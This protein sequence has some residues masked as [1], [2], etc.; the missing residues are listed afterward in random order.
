MLAEKSPLVGAHPLHCLKPELP[1]WKNKHEPIYAQIRAAKWTA[2]ESMSRLK[3]YRPVPSILCIGLNGNVFL[4]L[5][6]AP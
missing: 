2:G 5:K 1:T 6:K 3:S 4:S